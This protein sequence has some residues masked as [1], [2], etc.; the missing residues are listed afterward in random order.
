MASVTTRNISTLIESQLPAFIASEYQEFS[1]FVEKY[2]EHLE[3]RGGPL[4]IIANVTKYRDINFYEKNLLQQNTKVTEFVQDAATTIVVED[5]TSFPEENGYIKI[6]NE[7]CFYKSRTDTEFLEVSRGV[8]GNTTLGDLYGESNFVTT[9]AEPHYVNN[10]V[11]NI[12][13]LFLYALVKNFESQYLGGFPEKYLKG[14]V[15]KR[16]LIKNISSFYKSKGTDKSIK[17]IFNAIVAKDEEDIPEVYNPKDFTLK[18]STSDWISNYSL[19][20]KILFGQADNL[21]GRKIVQRSGD[22]YASA[23]VDAVRYGGSNDVFEIILSPSSVN[24]RFQIAAQTTLKTDITVASGVDDRVDVG[25]TAGWEGIPGTFVINT[26]NFTYKDKNVTQFI[27][28]DR[29]NPNTTHIAGTPVYS[30]DRITAETE[31]GIITLLA[32]GLV[33]NIN[34]SS[35]NPYSNSGDKVQISKPG[36]ESIHPAIDSS[37]WF[38]NEN[39]RKASSPLNP[40]ASAAISQFNSDVSAIYEDDQ[41][42]YIC[43]SGYPHHSLLKESSPINLVDGKFLKLV[44]KYPSNTTEIYETS[45]RDVAI[46]LDGSVAVGYRDQEEISSGKIETLTIQNKGVGYQSPPFVLLNNEPYKATAIM[47]GEVV[48]SVRV[49]IKDVYSNDP[50]VTIT[51]GRGAKVKP[52]VTSGEITS[53]IVTEPGEYYSSPPQIRIFDALGKGSFAEYEAVLTTDGR[54]A[55]CKKINGGRLYDRGSLIVDVIPVGSGAFAEAKVKRWIKDRYKLRQAELDDNNGLTFDEYSGRGK[56]YAVVANP[57]NLRYRLGDNINNVLTENSA[58]H[59]HSPIIGW[60]YD[61]NP[62]YGP[63]GYSEPGDPTSTIVRMNSGYV[64]QN[65]RTNGPDINQYEVGTFIDD[66]KWTPTINSGKTEL[67]ENNGRFCVTPEYPQGTYAYFVTIDS[68]GDPKF[69]YILGKNFYS[70]PVDSNYNSQMTQDDL[71]KNVRRLRSDTLDDN[72]IDTLATIADVIKG[73]VNSIYADQ[74][75]ENFSVGGEVFV[76]NTNTGG[77]GAKALVSEV[78]GRQVIALESESTNAVVIDTVTSA[79]F[80]AGDTVYQGEGI[81]QSEL[82][83]DT[84]T[85]SAFT[86]SS[87]PD[88]KVVNDLILEPPNGEYRVI[89][90]IEGEIIQGEVI[91]DVVNNNRVVLRRV[92]GE[93]DPSLPIFATIRVVNLLLS[94]DATYSEGAILSLVNDESGLT[95]GSGVVLDGTFKQN[96]VKIR[97][98]SGDFFNDGGYTL[99]S[100]VLENTSKSEVISV[101]SLSENIDIVSVKDNIGLIQTNENHNLGSGDK[102]NVNIFPDDD[103]TTTTYYVRK[104]LYQTVQIEPIAINSRINDTGVGRFVIMNSGAGYQEGTYSGVELYFQDQTKV[105]TNIG[106]PGDPNNARANITVYNIGGGFGRVSFIE[107]TEKGSGYRRGDVLTVA[108]NFLNRNVDTTSSARLTVSV[109]HV[110]FAADEIL[111][112]VSSATDISNN[113]KLRIGTEIVTV[114]GVDRQNNTLTVLR[115]EN[116]TRAVDHFNNQPLEIE[117]S[118]YK[119]DAN[120]QPLGADINK[121]YVVSYDRETKTLITAFSYTTASPITFL[122][123]SI[124]FDQNAPSKFVKIKSIEPAQYKL[125]FSTDNINFTVNPQIEVQKYYKYIFDT[126][127]SSMNNT[128]LDFS[129]SVNYNLLT[130]EKSVSTNLPGTPGSFVSL[131]LGFGPNISTNTYENEVPVNFNN[132]YYFIKASEDV[133]TEGASLKVIQDPLAGEHRVI[134]STANRFAYELNSVPQYDGSG[135][136][137]YTTSGAFAVGSITKLN[138]IDTG[139][140]YTNLPICRGILPT[141]DYL[142][143]LEAVV[144]TSNGSIGS[145]RVI[146]QGSNYSKPV[147]FVTNGDGVGAKFECVLENGKIKSIITR[148]GGKDYTFAEIKV[149]E[150]DV[151]A[152]FTSN[153]IGVPKNAKIIRSGYGYTSDYTTLPEFTSTLALALKDFGSTEFYSGEEIKQF[154]NGVVV[155]KGRVSKNGWRIGSNILKLE[156]VVGV[157]RNNT[158]IQGYFNGKTAN[159]VRQIVTDFTP[160]LRTYSDNLGRF[161]SERGQLSK[162]SQKLA[163]SYF[164]QDYS[165]VVKSKTSIEVWRDLIRET[166]HPAGFQLFGEMMVESEAQT[167]M[168]QESRVIETHSFINLEPKN[169][170]VVDTK[171][172]VKQTVLLSTGLNVQRGIGSVSVDTFDTG[173]T[174]AKEL[175]LDRPFN[176]DYNEDS[177]VLYG[178]T[179][180]TLIDPK[181]GTAYAPYSENGLII[182]IDGVLQEPGK[183]FT[184]QGNKIIFTEPPLG[185]R[186]AEGQEV[187]A[188]KFYCLSIK[189]KDDDLN[190]QYIRKIADISDQFDGIKFLF[191]LYNEDGGIVKTLPNEKLIVTLNGVLQRARKDEEVPFGNSYAIIRSVD[192]NRTD[193]IQFTEPPISHGE[194][195]E[196]DDDIKI[197]EKCFIYSVGSYTRLVIDEQTIK[198]KGGGPFLLRDEVTNDVVKVDAPEYAVVFVDGVLQIPGKSYNIVGPTITFDAPL[199]YHEEEDGTFYPQKVDVI[200]LYGRDK[201]KSLTFFDYEPDTFL[202]EATIKISNALSDANAASD[203]NDL[204]NWFINRKGNDVKLNQ[205]DDTLGKIKRAE[206]NDEVID[207]TAYRTLTLVINTPYFFDLKYGSD[208][209]DFIFSDPKTGAV[210]ELQIEN[211]FLPGPGNIP[212][213]IRSV[214]F[215]SDSDGNPLLGLDIPSWIKGTELGY[216]AYLNRSSI[217]ANLSPGDL[218]RIDGEKDYREILD[219]P[220]KVNSKQFNKNEFLSQDIYANIKTTNYNDIVRGEG[221]AITA[222]LDANGSVSKLNWN[223]RDLSLYFENDILIQSSAYQYFTPPIIEF[224]PTTN[225]GGGAKAQVIAT[226]GNVIDLVLLEGGYGYEEPPRVRVA[227]GFDRIK[228]NTRTIKSTSILDISPPISFP[229]DPG[230]RNSS[231]GGGGESGRGSGTYLATYTEIVIT[232]TGEAGESLFIFV[233]LSAAVG[234]LD[235]TQQVTII[236]AVTGAMSSMPPASINESEVAFTGIEKSV[237]SSVKVIQPAEIDIIRDPIPFTGIKQIESTASVTDTTTQIT[238]ILPATVIT[239]AVHQVDTASINDVGA[240]LD[241]PVDLDDN[242]I[243]VPDTRRFPKASRLLIGKEI[244]TYTKTKKDRFM[245]VERGTFGTEPQTH[246]AGD[247]LRHLP[248]LISVVPIGNIEVFS[249]ETSVRVQE[250]Q[251]QATTITA[252]SFSDVK[253]VNE[254]EVTTQV[255]RDTQIEQKYEGFFVSEEVIVIP[256]EFVTPTITSIHNSK[257]EVKSSVPPAGVEGAVSSGFV[258]LEDTTLRIVNTFDL[259]VKYDIIVSRQIVSE[260]DYDYSS[261]TS[262]K[263]TVTKTVNSQDQ[264]INVVQ[265]ELDFTEVNHSVVIDSKVNDI[266]SITSV[267]P[268]VE[269]LNPFIVS[270]YAT[271]D[272]NVKAFATEWKETVQLTQRGAIE[273]NVSLINVTSDVPTLNVEVL[274]IETLTEIQKITHTHVTL[275]EREE[276][277]EA[278]TSASV[279]GVEVTGVGVEGIVS[280]ARIDT[281]AIRESLKVLRLDINHELVI[282]TE[283]VRDPFETD[284]QQTVTSNFFRVEYEATVVEGGVNIYTDPSVKTVSSQ[285]IIKPQVDVV[286]DSLFTTTIQSINKQ[287][288][289]KPAASVAQ[290]ETEYGIT[291]V[292]YFNAPPLELATIEQVTIA[293]VERQIAVGTIAEESAETILSSQTSAVTNNLSATSSTIVTST[294]ETHHSIAN[295][296]TY[297]VDTT[298]TAF[299]TSITDKVDTLET[300]SSLVTVSKTAEIPAFFTIEPTISS[301]LTATS[302]TIVAS[303]QPDEIQ[304]TISITTGLAADEDQQNATREIDYEIGILDFFTELYVLPP[305]IKT[306][307]QGEFDLNDPINEVFTREQGTI[308]VLNASRERESFYDGYTVGNAGFTMTGFENNL[309]IDTG[310]LGVS[311]DIDD[312]TKM[313]PDM[314]IEDFTERHSSAVTMTGERFN[315]GIPTINEVGSVL[316]ASITNQTSLDINNAGPFPDSGVILIG[317]EL[318]KYV[319]K[320]GNT[321]QDLTRGYEGTTPSGH[322]AG[323]YVRTFG[324]SS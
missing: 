41:Y 304:H 22:N 256:P 205:K 104:R 208:D 176:G 105:R 146:N 90:A 197:A 310:A 132:Y 234:N 42:F 294:H 211:G 206:F 151:T 192:P 267:L 1:K 26:E 261:V 98:T 53:I 84:R 263:S 81:T 101:N 58:P 272:S 122:Q 65:N 242:I 284:Y 155:A 227:R 165:Y 173:E 59:T 291:R 66:W 231:S 174:V 190:E 259:G 225:A 303:T 88:V 279:V 226:G 123:S 6:G 60:A 119:L 106:R 209:L 33:Y 248:E 213:Q 46:F 193:Q 235:T 99:K 306:R 157:F 91:G 236:P 287:V 264:F 222:E 186:I 69:P 282:S 273:D 293:N 295:T 219:L 281:N 138:I 23:V 133:N 32:L 137:S 94:N 245:Y 277:L 103:L 78:T 160:D 28:A 20:A 64:L 140:N 49:D 47:A 54:L 216:Q 31:N 244:V 30:G 210:I 207:G 55:S 29:S 320:S 232:Q 145:V 296:V 117:E 238:S 15:D 255:E 74:S 252:T 315:M 189:F 278:L 317:T 191:D 56:H 134:Y 202:A 92:E 128:F 274:Q 217:Y 180:Y 298:I 25:S 275:S 4:D 179:I 162:N 323:E 316:S 129:A 175:V 34:P 240:F 258:T 147:A 158:P 299:S 324:S 110:G 268:G 51:S 285:H 150:S 181:E 307:T 247:Y 82:I 280:S 318:I 187:V 97:V 27:L 136:I 80:F 290:V 215:D 172:F 77:S 107:L 83:T 224:I 161:N 156:N 72:G 260:T 312:I 70:L 253:S 21:V 2:Y 183:S 18:A 85:V 68:S 254:L 116:N 93:F 269:K 111:I 188:Q 251:S 11:Y 126:S 228:G 75:V 62:I 214:E 265:R 141:N 288:T 270:T 266:D 61:G 199:N 86:L 125:E 178:D 163:D 283:V 121:P 57:G 196:S 112:N 168:P 195:Y 73:N 127:H 144:D 301:R 96:S 243:F 63:Y 16:T 309:M 177:G 302:T 184:V 321:L 167:R 314:T 45:R 200:L 249:I 124:F 311:G 271:S 300:T 218:I 36:F 8:S 115:G 113:D 102:I 109:D 19:K 170:S 171:K 71:P 9:Q 194:L 319:S 38:V 246:N 169:I 201:E 79:Y 257:S 148:N 76:D 203:L 12:S 135:S 87:S 43:S 159:I 276:V 39:Y 297:D 52:I 95:F 229:A 152:F 305:K 100:N 250:T 221:L 89:Q 154:V 131:K 13:N 40:L 322:S 139:S 198:Y 292:F 182:T 37:D 185:I 308:F 289:I 10:E 223:R 233:D 220:E 149:F 118:F 5:A 108:D 153:N 50:D 230:A 313:F 24:G 241:A 7:I 262:L 120:Y 142:A 204:E 237:S 48:Q 166:T 14:E 44:R 164:Y 239:E 130:S 3:N 143:E 17:F 286:S 114:T 67:D 212:V 35:P